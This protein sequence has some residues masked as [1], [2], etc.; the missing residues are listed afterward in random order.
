M[1]FSFDQF[2][3]QL[4]LLSF[5]WHYLTF[6]HLLVLFLSLQSQVERLTKVGKS[7]ETIPF[8][9]WVWT[10]RT[11]IQP[12]LPPTCQHLD[13]E[14]RSQ[15]YFRLPQQQQQQRQCKQKQQP[16]NKMTVFEESV[17]TKTADWKFDLR[18]STYMRTLNWHTSF[19]LTSKSLRQVRDPDFFLLA[20][21]SAEGRKRGSFTVITGTGELEAVKIF[22]VSLLC[23]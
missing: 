14:L 22:I 11:C 5:R 15:N 2:R 21:S 4:Y 17:I 16:K 12:L 9:E 6:R 7:T 1:T 3:F 8:E 20:Q 10:A 18:Q 19:K 13:F 23:V